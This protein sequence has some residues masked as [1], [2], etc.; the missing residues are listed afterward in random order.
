MPAPRMRANGAGICFSNLSVCFLLYYS[1]FPFGSCRR[2]S[3]RRCGCSLPATSPSVKPWRTSI[4]RATSS[5]RAHGFMCALLHTSPSHPIYLLTR[6]S[7][8]EQCVH[9]GPGLLHPHRQKRS[10]EWRA[11]KSSK[12]AAAA[13]HQYKLSFGHTCLVFAPSSRACASKNRS[14][15]HVHARCIVRPLLMWQVA[16]CAIHRDPQVWGNPEEYVPERWVAGA[17]EE[18]TEAQKKVRLAHSASR[19]T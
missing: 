11:C 12:Q 19:A 13:A 16:V 3:R 4:W 1:H 15:H 9:G 10:M 2:A 14:A 6:C 5:P 18:A 17:P 8:R 7:V